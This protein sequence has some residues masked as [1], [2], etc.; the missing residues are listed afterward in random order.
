MIRSFVYID[1]LHGG[2]ALSF[3]IGRRSKVNS[4]LVG[5]VVG[6]VMA[7]G[8]QAQSSVTLYGVIDEQ[9]YPDGIDGWMVKLDA[10]GDGGVS[11]DSKFF[12][13]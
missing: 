5:G 7:S 9:F 4:K 3:N 8:A 10:A 1:L 12:V 2:K 13:Q 11:F 6:L